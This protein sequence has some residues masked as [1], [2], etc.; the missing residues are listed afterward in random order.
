VLRLGGEGALTLLDSLTVRHRTRWDGTTLVVE[1][2]PEG[3]GTLTERYQLAD[4]GQYLRVDVT[5]EYQG[6]RRWDSRLYRRAS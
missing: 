2:R 4:S 6:F 3:G 1:W 5:V